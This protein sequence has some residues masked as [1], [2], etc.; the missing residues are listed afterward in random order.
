MIRFSI[1][2]VSIQPVS[3]RPVSIRPVSIQP[4]SIRPGLAFAPRASVSQK[5]SKMATQTSRHVDVSLR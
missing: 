2:P 5:E 4:V 3:I 1:Q